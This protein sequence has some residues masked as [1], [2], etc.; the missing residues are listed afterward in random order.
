MKFIRMM[1]GC[2]RPD[3]MDLYT[4]IEHVGIPRENPYAKYLMVWRVDFPDATSK[5]YRLLKDAKRA[6]SDWY[7]KHD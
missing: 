7:A 4:K 3:D 1:D 2:Y 5:T 6:L